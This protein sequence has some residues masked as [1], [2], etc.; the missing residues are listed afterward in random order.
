MAYELYWISGSPNAWRAMF[1]MELKGLDYISHRLDPS[2]GEHKS[3]EMMPLNP[4]GKV[5][6]LKDGDVVIYESIAILAYLDQKH[7]APA[8]FGDNPVE[9]GKIWQRIFEMMNYAREPIEDGIT[10][11]LFRGQAAVVGDAIKAAAIESH[12]ALKWVEGILATTPYLAGDKLSAADIT[13]MPII[14]VLIR[15]GRRDDAIELELGFDTFAAHYPHITAWLAK[16]EALPEYDK[17][18]PPH[19]RDA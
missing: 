16:I 11:P 1:A 2:K 8:L 3:P 12:A 17:A 9:T 15:A 10:R 18:Y 4:H 5:P 14:Q 7:P 6:V 13:F 19:W